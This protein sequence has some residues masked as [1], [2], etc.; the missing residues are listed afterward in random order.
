MSNQKHADTSEMYMAHAM[1]RREFG[2]LPALIRGAGDGDR[3][4]AR[5]I[6]DHFALIQVV[7]YHHHHGEDT[8]TWPLLRARGGA[9]AGAVADVME[10][11]HGG[12]DAVLEEV[13][14]GLAGWRETANPAQRAAVAD[15]ADRL[16]LLLEEHLATEE[17]RALPLIERYV[18]E[19]EWD[20]GVQE[21]I[22]DVAAKLAPDQMMLLT[23]MTLYEA[24]PEATR[25]VIANVPPEFRPAIEGGLIAETFAR[26]SEVVHGTP[27]P[28]RIGAPR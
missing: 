3:E 11:Q 21:E 18:T 19:A 14:S 7:L 9:G 8:H 12:I 24:S 5:V 25:K 1:F 20:Q 17:E 2:L 16:R 13:T 10:S 26:Y 4:R 15:A 22:A 6:A 23:G 28:A 27:A